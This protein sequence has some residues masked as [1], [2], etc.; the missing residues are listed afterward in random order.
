LVPMLD[1]EISLV[2]P[3]VHFLIRRFI[4]SDIQTS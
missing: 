2:L 4:A 3:I 1:P